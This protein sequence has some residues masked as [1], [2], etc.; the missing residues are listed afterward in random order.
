M[1]TA[2]LTTSKVSLNSCVV[3]VLARALT[4]AL[5][6]LA[7]VFIAFGIYRGNVRVEGTGW[8]TFFPYAAIVGVVTVLIVL[9][10]T[11]LPVREW[12]EPEASPHSWMSFKT[13]CQTDAP[14]N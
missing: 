5:V 4:W 6:E 2:P 14:K 1:D 13:H 8:V 11:S 12:Y 3:S 10:Y 9:R 7:L